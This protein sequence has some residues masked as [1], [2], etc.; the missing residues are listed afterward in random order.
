ML[1]ALLVVASSLCAGTSQA[2]VVP[3]VDSSGILT[4]ATGVL[5]NGQSYDVSFMD[6]TCAALFSGCDAASDFTFQSQVDAQA[7]A[8]A[9]DAQVFVSTFD[10]NPNLTRDCPVGAN[11][12]AFTPFAVVAGTFPLVTTFSLPNSLASSDCCF[13]LGNVSVNDDQS[14]SS[15]TFTSTWAVWSTPVPEPSS[16]ALLAVG[17][18]A[19]G[20]AHRRRCVGVAAHAQ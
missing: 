12:F 10:T 19:L 17:L 7:A 15:T 11:C 13:T 2:A 3:Q 4:G 9:L 6:G 5:V 8:L 1:L 20:W 16:Y 18:A 14:F